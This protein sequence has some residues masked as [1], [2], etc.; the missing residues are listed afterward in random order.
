MQSAAGELQRGRAS[1]DAVDFAHHQQLALLGQHHAADAD[2]VGGE[3]GQPGAIL[4]NDGQHQVVFAAV[5]ESEALVH[6]FGNQRGLAD[7]H[8]QP[9]RPHSVGSPLLQGYFK[10]LGKF[11]GV[12]RKLARRNHHAAEGILPSFQ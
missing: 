6:C 12:G 11:G 4:E 10:P 5:V 1:G 2:V 7:R 3:V 8:F 9:R